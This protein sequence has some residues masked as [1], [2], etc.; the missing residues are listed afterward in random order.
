[1]TI[2]KFWL[3]ATVGLLAL[4]SAMVSLKSTLMYDD[5]RAA[6]AMRY[7]G[8]FSDVT[9]IARQSHPLR[10]LSIGLETAIWET[11]SMGFHATNLVLHALTAMTLLVLLRRLLDSHPAAVW[12][13]GLFAVMPIGA[14]AVG[15]VAHRNEILGLLLMLLTCL[16]WM[17]PQRGW[18]AWGAGGICALLATVETSMSLL[19]PLLL[20]AYDWLLLAPVP[21][22]RLRPRRVETGGAALALVAV[23]LTYASWFNRF[24]IGQ[25]ESWEVI[26]AWSEWPIRLLRDWP[27]GVWTALRW[28]V[29]PLPFDYDHGLTPAS[30][31]ATLTGIVV[32]FALGTVVWSQART[33]PR[34]AFGA[35]WLLAGCAVAR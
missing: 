31:L 28:L 7:I 2:T 22:D 1:M 34:L 8:S 18:G 20:I 25:L 26:P 9:N 6:R 27:A 23:H 3:Y 29:I 30:M 19:L 13:A 15:V 21:P 17:R 24:G 16:A 10:Q 32:I 35:A 11:D 4:P 14:A 5:Q 12:A 33:R